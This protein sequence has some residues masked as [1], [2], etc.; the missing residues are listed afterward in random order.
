[1]SLGNR[2]KK[3]RKR[4]KLTQTELAQ[5]LGGWD[6][7]TISK[8]ESNTYEP[9]VSN[10]KKLSQILNVTT[11]YL[12]GLT[13]NQVKKD[14]FDHM[15]IPVKGHPLNQIAFFNNEEWKNL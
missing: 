14:S 8:W 4:L 2:I 7:T 10:I 13:D 9:D 11:D 12:L 5:K 1:M 3:C 15:D 6:H